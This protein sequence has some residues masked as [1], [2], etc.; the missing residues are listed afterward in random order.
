[1]MMLNFVMCWNMSKFKT[2]LQKNGINIY[3]IL[4]QDINIWT[5]SHQNHRNQFFFIFRN[6]KNSSKHHL[7]L[8]WA[9][10]MLT[11]LIFS[12][13]LMLQFV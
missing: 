11:I 3:Q 6:T 12:R 10:L 2:C 7:I 1:M 5:T 13:L 9:S 4:T 8:M